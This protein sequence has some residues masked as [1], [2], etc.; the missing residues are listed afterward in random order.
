M[1][2]DKVGELPVQAP[3]RFE[4]V[5]DIKTADALA[6]KSLKLFGHVVTR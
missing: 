1:I 4:L 3:D 6:S 5:I 2:A